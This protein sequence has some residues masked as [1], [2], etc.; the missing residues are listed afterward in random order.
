MINLV[1]YV[2]RKFYGETMKKILSL[3]ITIGMSVSLLVGCNLF[4]VNPKKYYDQVVA[5]VGNHSFTMYDLLQAY[6]LNGENYINNGSSYE[7]AIN[8][9]L[10]DLIDKTLLIDYVKANNIVALDNDDYNDIKLSV[11][12]S[13]QSSITS[14]ED[15]IKVER[16][17]AEEDSEESGSD[18]GTASAEQNSNYVSKFMVDESKQEFDI[19][20]K[21][22]VNPD[23]GKDPGEFVQVKDLIY[24]DI[25][26]E[27][28]NR[29]IKTL[30]AQ[31]RKY[32]RS[33]KVE[34]VKS[35]EFDRLTKAFTENKYIEKL[36][37]DYYK[38]MDLVKRDVVNS[39]VNSYAED[40]VTYNNK[41]VKYNTT[42]SNAASSYAGDMYY[43]PEVNYMAV[44]HILL[45]YDVPTETQ[46]ALLKNKLE[47]GDPDYNEEEYKKDVLAL[48][49][50]MQ[51]E[52][53]D[54]KGTTRYATASEVFA[55]VKNEIS[56]IE[57]EDL[58]DRAK[59]FYK[60]MD[61]FND[62]EGITS[63]KYGYLIPLNITD[64]NGA[65]DSMIAE[66]ADDS[67]A[68]N[69]ENALG[70]NISAELVLGSY[71]Y[72]I[73]FNMGELKNLF[74]LEEMQNPEVYFDKIWKTLFNTTINLTSNQ[75]LFDSIYDS[76]AGDEDSLANTYI[77][78]LVKTAK[79]GLEIKKYEGRYDNLW[80]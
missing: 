14:F 39:Y 65:K 16:G 67:R 1:Q 62:D 69:E 20:R 33:D 15:Q 46:I 72:H 60:L 35:A 59:K 38:D 36:Q 78:E 61:M 7:E 80:K 30:Q 21:P 42:M 43:H 44:S 48:S 54:E 22:T 57:I 77:S 37:E 3:L 11:Y 19:V 52:Y 51:V 34:D 8:Q 24:P 23:Y 29:Y 31:A 9:C 73:I 27:A 68:L 47:S 40:Y 2:V 26:D 45:K 41:N 56:E 66:F 79:S 64:N 25:S 55:K 50:T 18:E 49:E 6:E 63:A 10:D 32:G 76:L 13:I 12:T 5:T 17:L 53:V 71:G 58:S 75:T 74:T 70:G 4:S 28:Y